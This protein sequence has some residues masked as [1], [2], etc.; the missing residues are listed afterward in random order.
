MPRRRPRCWRLGTDSRSRLKPLALA[1]PGRRNQSLRG[2]VAARNRDTDRR[3][4]LSKPS[5][6]GRPLHA[7]QISDQRDSDIW[8]PS[9]APL[10]DL[11][12]KGD[13]DKGIRLLGAQGPSP[14]A[15]SRAARAL[16]DPA[17]DPDPDVASGAERRSPLCRC[18]R[19]QPSSEAGHVGDDARFFASHGAAFRNVAG[20][21]GQGS[22]EPF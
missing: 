5:R 15:R 4:A 6:S 9:I 3:N 20:A 16:D 18:A 10:I 13:V 7:S 11:F 8:I 14:P 17:R 1:Q 21:D 12:R 22:A 2:P 19:C